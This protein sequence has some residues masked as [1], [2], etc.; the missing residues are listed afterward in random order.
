MSDRFQKVRSSQP[1]CEITRAVTWADASIDIG[2]QIL[3]PDATKA[4]VEF[5]LAHALPVITKRRTALHPQVVANSFASMHHQ[6]FNLAHLMKAYDTAENPITRDRILGSIVAVE[7]PRAPFGGWKVQ[8]ERGQ[9]P[10]IRAAAVVHKRAEGVDRII[11]SQQSGRRKWS[12]SLEADYLLQDSGFI[13]GAGT[14][15]GEKWKKLG[16]DWKTP[17]DLLAAGWVYIPCVK[18]PDALL[19]CLDEET[20]AIVKADWEKMEVALLLGGLDGTVHFKGTGMC[21]LGTEQEKEAKVLSL[22]AADW[23]E[24]AA[25]SAQA[26]VRETPDPVAELIGKTGAFL[27]CWQSQKKI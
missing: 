27:D 12:V 14:T 7:F 2:G 23:T 1:W 3:A 21:P 9:S 25:D 8:K 20:G 26:G 13:V 5:H 16:E 4:Y 24:G 18:A 6:V 22:V 10:G 15:K 17:A 11:G 19:D